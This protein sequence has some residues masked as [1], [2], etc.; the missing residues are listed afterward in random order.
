MHQIPRPTALVLALAAAYLPL[1][2]LACDDCDEG[3][4]PV[5]ANQTSQKI[6][7][8]SE[9]SGASPTH[10][11]GLVSISGQALSSLP[12]Q[13]PTTMEG[14]SAVE[15][16]RTINATDAE[17]ALKYLPSLL[18]RKR[19][20]GDYNHA[21]LS[22]R[23]SGT[24]NSA[25]SLV[26]ADG[27][28]LS[29]LLGNG[30]GFTPRWGLVTPEEIERVDVLYGPFSAAYSGNSVGAV[31][32][33]QTRMPKAF[34]AHAKLGLFQQPF[35]LYNS[36][37]SYSGH[38]ASASLGD[39]AGA[40]SWWIHVKRLDSEGQPLTF[41]TKLVSSGKPVNAASLPV[42]GAVLD[43]D[44]SN[45]PW[46]I[47]GTGTQYHT[48]QDHAKLKLAYDFDSQLRASYSLAWWHN[49]SEGVSESYLRD[50]GGNTVY[51][52]ANI[53]ID[54]KQYSVANTDFGQSRD[55]LSHLMHGL[56]LKSYTRGPFDFELSA[57]QYDYRSDTAR[58]PSSPK[59]LA[60]PA[61]DQGG[62]GRL[63][64]L[65]GTG[66]TALAAKAI[67]RPSGSD[68]VLD[69]GLQQERYVWQ[70]TT[71][72]T[73]DWIHGA[74]SA[75]FTAFSG[76]TQLRSAYAQDS[77]TLSP[78][79]KTVLGLRAEE[80]QAMDGRKTAANGTPV[81]F[82][83]RKQRFLSPKAALGY[84]LNEDWTLRV[85]TG[86]AVRM[87]TVGELYQGGVSATGVYLPNDPAT[88]PDLKPERGWTS[89]FS[90]SWS[91]GKQQLRSTLFH[92]NTRDALYSQ[93]S[94]KPADP[95]KTIS[96]VQNI[97]RIRTLGLELAYS[98]QDL[99]ESLGLKG[100]ELQS[101]L[102]YADSKILE[103]SGFVS[104]PGDTIGRQQPR[105]PRWRATVLASYAIQP[106]LHLS[107]GL[108]Y[109]GPQ[110]GTLNNSDPNGHTYQGFSKFLT[111]DLRLQWKLDKQWTLA[112]GIDNLNNDKYWAFH[113]YPNRSY[114]AELKFDL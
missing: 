94:S 69:L 57:S 99:G 46:Q 32:D 52:G 17:D 20:I 76:K 110:Y 77:W 58:S 62:A 48:V 107:Y 80:W 35:D 70:Q 103:N 63:T 104:T 34:E 18:V 98:A 19:Y 14:V 7:A 101:S 95:S 30:A 88:N 61:A 55:R 86:R 5:A 4:S 42:S 82:A 71:S 109:S 53:A 108:R 15:I 100:L 68:H 65:G 10:K 54:G 97:G 36:H 41:V 29:N 87:P 26:F 11:L 45:A 64:D 74:P 111:G 31:V 24:G 102:T 44:K 93:L 22:T 72:D 13:I 106:N 50:A 51:S 2:A 37:R 1:T 92:E 85:S 56:T 75:L 67:W 16:A 83:A 66:W 38:Q 27:I 25:R 3:A 105:V 90:A 113:P 112:A 43:A 89:E 8:D 60:R 114:H 91:Q 78:T 21:V 79:L 96:S 59:S 40:L 6:S 84:E 9:P 47:L 39:R 33:Y 81:A 28:Q 12:S 23:A 73:E 49:Q